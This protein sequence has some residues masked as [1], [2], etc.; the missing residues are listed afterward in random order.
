MI[1][2]DGSIERETLTGRQ[3]GTRLWEIGAILLQDNN[4]FPITRTASGWM[5]SDRT[6]AMPLAP[7]VLYTVLYDPEPTPDLPELGDQLSVEQLDGLPPG[8]VVVAK[9]ARDAVEVAFQCTRTFPPPQQLPSRLLWASHV[10]HGLKW[11]SERLIG[12]GPVTLVWRPDL[13]DQS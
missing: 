3:V 9:V 1:K 13:G 10:T 8:S 11:T 12:L 4:R 5:E 2:Q 6:A 7:E